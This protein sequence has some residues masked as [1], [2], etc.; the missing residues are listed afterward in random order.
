MRFHPL[1]TGV[2]AALMAALATPAAQAAKV[3]PVFNA[4]INTTHGMAPLTVVVSVGTQPGESSAPGWCAGVI[5]GD[6]WRDMTCRDCACW[7]GSSFTHV[8][9]EEGTYTIHAWGG[10]STYTPGFFADWTV[11]VDPEPPH[12]GEHGALSMDVDPQAGAGPLVA[13]VQGYGEADGSVP[14]S[15]RLHVDFG[16]GTAA[17]DSGSCVACVDSLPLHVPFDYTHAYVCAGTYHVTLTTPLADCEDCV[18]VEHDVTVGPHPAVVLT[19]VYGGD[20]MSVKLTTPSPLMP[21]VDEA[22]VSWGD[23]GP[24]EPLSWTSA[25]S[26][27]ETPWHR[28]AANAAFPVRITNL[29]PSPQCVETLEAVVT[30][31]GTP[32]AVHNTTWG[33]VKAFY[34]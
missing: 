14:H 30:V 4:T 17:S 19:P 9:E 3:D 27:F 32:T 20:G 22:W 21:F 10:L 34:R 7:V 29:F 13:H 26:W 28:Y 25:G 5:A 15:M 33:R 1:P 11:V 16:D 6:G 2:V 8:F 31:P 12:G 24:V 23:N 18:P